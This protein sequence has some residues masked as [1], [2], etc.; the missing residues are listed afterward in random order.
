MKTFA[1]AS[2]KP[3]HTGSTG[4]VLT[5][6]S[7]LGWWR[8]IHIDW[9][10]FFSRC[11]WFRFLPRKPP[12]LAVHN[13][14]FN[15]GYPLYQHARQG[16]LVR[17]LFA[18]LGRTGMDVHSL[19]NKGRTRRVGRPPVAWSRHS[20]L[21]AAYHVKTWREEPNWREFWQAKNRYGM[22]RR[23]GQTKKT[24]SIVDPLP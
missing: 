16:F 24:Q 5:R 23:S 22:N 3:R 20:F 17:S 15:S 4:P 14:A 19:C 2:E 18:C 12:Y 1:M 6:I 7:A 8:A 11:P 9:C 13:F 10:L 21:E